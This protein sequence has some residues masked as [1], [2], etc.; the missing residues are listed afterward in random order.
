MTNNSNTAPEIQNILEFIL[1]ETAPG[2]AD[3]TLRNLNHAY[4]RLS[5]F[6]IRRE[7]IIEEDKAAIEEFELFL[8]FLSQLARY[9]SI[10]T[11][12]S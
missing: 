6:L 11:V 9:Q 4:R 2:E 8:N 10:K 1:D 12:K 3:A 7:E 5:S